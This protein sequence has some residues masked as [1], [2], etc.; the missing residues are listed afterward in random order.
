MDLLDRLQHAIGPPYRI[1]CDLG[2]GGMSTVF[3]AA[4]VKHERKLP[5]RSRVAA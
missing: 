3:L 1:E 5:R 4:D 2:Q